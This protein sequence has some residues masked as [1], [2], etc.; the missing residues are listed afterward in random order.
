MQ[1]R[2]GRSHKFGNVLVIRY[3]QSPVEPIVY[4]LLCV[5][6]RP[7][8]SVKFSVPA[9]MYQHVFCSEQHALNSVCLDPMRETSLIFS[10]PS[11]SKTGIVI[12]DGCNLRL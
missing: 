12:Q 1:L 11:T 6:D 3:Y 5:D 4:V 10:T 2:T 8:L 7:C 9:K